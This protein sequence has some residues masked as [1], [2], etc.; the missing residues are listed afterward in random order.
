[1]KQFLNPEIYKKIC[2]YLYRYRFL[3]T[4]S[5]IGVFSLLVEIVCYNWLVKI[6]LPIW[7]AVIIGL[8]IGIFFAFWM[9]V[10]FNFKVPSSKRNRSLFYFA[11]ISIISATI[12]FIFK[13]KLEALGYSYEFSRFTVAGTFFLMA[14]VFHRK[15]SFRD[16]KKVGVA[17]YANGVEDIKS[18]YEKIGS[19]SDFIHVD[20]IDDSFGETTNE[21]KTYRLEVIRAYW[22]KKKIHVHIMSRTPSKWLDE[23]LKYC[24]SIIIHTEID[25]NISE[26]ISNI[27]KQQK[28]IGLCMTM[29]TSLEKLKPFYK[30]I[31]EIMLLTINKPGHSGQ[32]FEMPALKKIEEINNWPERHKLE[33]CVDGGIDEKNIGLLNVE[34]VV[35]GSSVLNNPEPKKQIMRL[36]TSSSYEKI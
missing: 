6:G 14:Y 4:Y 7:V 29:Q 30:N 21:V 34:K 18:I 33:L 15:F 2:F 10:R 36:Q 31:D 1:M 27:R 22:P 24:D 9:N 3:A 26:L 17:I 8:A 5:I 28:R 12:N 23:C 25:E 16:Y 11:T 20:I 13:N 32:E 19:F 35:S